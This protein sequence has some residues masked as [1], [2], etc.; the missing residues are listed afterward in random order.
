MV[1]GVDDLSTGRPSNIADLVGHKNFTFVTRPCGSAHIPEGSVVFHLA[2]KADIVPSIEKPWAY[3]ETNVNETIRLLENCR[4]AKIKRFIYA[5]SSSCYG[6]PDEIP[7]TEGAEIRPM[8]PYALTKWIGEQCALHWGQVYGIEVT[9]L[10]LF[11]VYGPNFRTNGTYGA[12]FGVFLAQI[13][14][15]LPVTIVGDGEQTRDF[16]FVKDICRAFLL[17]AEAKYTGIFNI[18]SGGSYSINE[19]VRR[20]GAKDITYIPERPGEPKSTFALISKA[21][22]FLKYEPKF[23][24]ET[25]VEIMKEHLNDYKTAPTWT[26]EKIEAATKD[27]FKYLGKVQE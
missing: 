24:F 17:A 7:T 10:R 13:A 12:V 9:S 6:L 2:A 16:T 18:G 15:G 11:N 4:H 21:K 23:S 20:L 1:I 8:Y 3:H 14:N 25:G 26:V 22:V 27:W 19:L 5:A